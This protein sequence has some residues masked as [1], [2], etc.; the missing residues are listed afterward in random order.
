MTTPALGGVLVVAKPAGMT[1]FD[2]VAGVRRVLHVRRAGHAG[3]LDPAATG[4]LPVLL[5]EATKLMAYLADEDKEYRVTV[6]F[7][8]TTDTLDAGGRVLSERTVTGLRREDVERATIRFLG[9]I[10]QVPPMYSARHHEGRRLYELAREG[11]EVERAPREVVVHSIAVE[12]VDD[13]SATL[14]IVCGKGTYVRVL[15]SE[16]G[17]ALGFGGCVERL[18]RTRVGPFRL[19]EAVAWDD[20]THGDA[21]ALRA[22]VL[23]PEAA[24]AR[25]P[26]VR[27]APDAERAF[28]CGQSVVAPSLVGGHGLLRVHAADGPLL[29]VGEAVVGGGRVRPVRILHVDRPRTRVLPA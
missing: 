6:R 20:L 11:L 2:V 3:T 28:V 29:G 15:A 4:V 7:G 10:R 23:P 19:A 12:E 27:L 14:A 22:R 18:I 8:I 17:E 16:L 26:E 9:V 24:L 1:S 21:A 5:G 13:A 25:W